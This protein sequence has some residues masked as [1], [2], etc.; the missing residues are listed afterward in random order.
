[1]PV[2]I[3]KKIMRSLNQNPKTKNLSLEKRKRIMYSIMNKKGLLNSK[4]LLV[5]IFANVDEAE[6][7]IVEEIW[8]EVVTSIMKEI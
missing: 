6:A 2:E 7:K 5:D 3:E 8:M 4:A 1:M